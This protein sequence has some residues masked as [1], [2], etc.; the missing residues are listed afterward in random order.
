MMTFTQSPWSLSDLFPAHDSPEMKA[1]FDE[2]D[3]K[4]VEFEALRPS[5][6]PE[7]PPDAFLNTIRLLEAIS[8][9]ANRVADFAGLSFAADTQDQAI[10][11]FQSDVDS[12]MALL[13]N[14]VLFFS[15]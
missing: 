15:L 11:S 3:V 8:R 10:Q 14:R 5:L 2:L 9:L 13:S 7:M 4:V 12:R 1:A 6:S